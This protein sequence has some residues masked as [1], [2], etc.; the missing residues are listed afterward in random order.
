MKNQARYHLNESNILIIQWVCH[1]LQS[2]HLHLFF[3]FSVS[4]ERQEFPSFIPSTFQFFLLC[5]LS[6]RTTS[7]F[8]LFN[9]IFLSP[10]F[11]LSRVTLF[12]WQVMCDV[13][14][15]RERAETGEKREWGE[16]IKL[17]V[18][19]LQ[20]KSLILFSRSFLALVRHSILPLFLIVTLHIWRPLS[21]ALVFRF[22]YFWCILAFLCMSIMLKSTTKYR[23]KEEKNAKQKNRKKRCF[24]VVVWVIRC[25]RWTNCD[26]H[27]VNRKRHA[28]VLAQRKLLY[29]FNF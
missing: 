16:D 28:N 23:K 6:L 19:S 8:F 4:F 13:D 20:S 25:K 17:T 1:G 2:L 18:L 10:F 26:A 12:E 7:L 14:R 29:Y 24:R 21:F 15:E 22:C 3:I 5:R 27:E 11:S 9:F